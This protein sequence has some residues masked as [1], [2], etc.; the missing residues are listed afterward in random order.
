MRHYTDPDEQA[1][2][3]VAYAR[4]K[5]GGSPLSPLSATEPVQFAAFNNW[6]NAY[7]AGFNDGAWR[8]DDQP[9]PAD[10]TGTKWFPYT[11]E[12]DRGAASTWAQSEA[13]T[14]DIARRDGKRWRHRH[15]TYGG[16][17]SGYIVEPIP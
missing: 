10:P 16:T 4:G 15:C 5:R 9:P 7:G 8:E 11:T 2:Y 14:R 13:R 1:A 3:D 17:R 12:S 6:P